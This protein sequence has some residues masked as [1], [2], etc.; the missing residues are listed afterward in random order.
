[1]TNSNDDEH[2]LKWSGLIESKVRL[3]V[4]KLEQLPGIKLVHPFIKP[5]ET[6]YTMSNSESASSSKADSSSM[7]KEIIDKY[8]T[9]LMESYLDK[10]YVKITDDN[11]DQYTN[12]NKIF[13]TTMYIGFEV[14]EEVLKPIGVQNNEVVNGKNNNDKKKYKVDIHVPCTEFY[15]LCHNFNEEYND[16]EK[17]QLIIRYVKGIE[18]LDN[19]FE[20]GESRVTKKRKMDLSKDLSNNKTL[21]KSRKQTIEA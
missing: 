19:V 20:E 7:F 5:I 11:K 13:I 1:M 8:G 3:L 14:D 12:V 10:K 4:L 17:F 6:L 16:T 9:H 2:H 21:K 15:N 18:L